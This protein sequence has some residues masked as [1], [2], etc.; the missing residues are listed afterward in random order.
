MCRYPNTPGIW[1]KEQVE[2][3]KPIVDVVHAKGATFFVQI[4]HVG[5]VSDTGM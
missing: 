3:W 5:R 1:T 4:V 2:A